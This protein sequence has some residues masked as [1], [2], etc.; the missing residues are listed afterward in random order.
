MSI[1][2]FSGSMRER[3]GQIVSPAVEKTR[4]LGVEEA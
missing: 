1:S 4:S 2:A 3:S